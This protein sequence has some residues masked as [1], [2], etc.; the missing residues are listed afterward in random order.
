MFFFYVAFNIFR[1]VHYIP[2][3]SRTFIMDCY[4]ILSNIFSISNKMILCF[5]D[6]H[7]FTWWIVLIN[8]HMLNHHRISRMKLLDH[9]GQLFLCV[10]TMVFK[11]LCSFF[12]S[13]TITRHVAL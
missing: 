2:T 4:W 7:L 3:L 5:V 12:F 11:H 8:L 6:L 9:E 13:S 1:Y 10:L